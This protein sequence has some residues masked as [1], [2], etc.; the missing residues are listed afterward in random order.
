MSG[1]PGGRLDSQEAREG[2]PRSN[3]RWA[4]IVNP[5]LNQSPRIRRKD[6][7]RLVAQG[8]AE[9]VASD[10]LRLVAAHS[11]NRANASAAAVGYNN[12][13]A[14]LVRSADE[15]RHVPIIRPWIA[16]TER[17]NRVQKHSAE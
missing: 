12:A 2:Q 10:Q 14:A 5:I 16:L 4:V 1:P 7:E 6:A 3:P 15:L 11:A 8:R 13:A 9:W 17:N